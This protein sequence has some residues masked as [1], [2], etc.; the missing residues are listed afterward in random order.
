MADLNIAQKVVDYV[1]TSDAVATYLQKS[2]TEKQAQAQKIDEM[3]PKAVEALL[4]NHRIPDHLQKKASTLLKDPVSALEILIHT[5]NHRNVEETTHMGSEV[6]NGHQK[7]AHVRG[8]L[9][10]PYVG[11]RTTEERDS[12]RIF[13]EKIGLR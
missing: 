1:R 12:D 2:E 3:V 5:A 7:K 11:G 13:L 4:K 9:N 6:G 8:S 10:S